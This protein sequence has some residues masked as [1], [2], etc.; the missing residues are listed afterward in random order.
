MI[1]VFYRCPSPDSPPYV[2]VGDAI[3]AGQTV[4]LIEAMKVFSE[5]P[6][7]RGGKVVA[8]PAENGKLV[9]QGDSLVVIDTSATE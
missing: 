7:E 1:G 9:Q 4:G 2:E 6:A 5:V 3:E 8:T